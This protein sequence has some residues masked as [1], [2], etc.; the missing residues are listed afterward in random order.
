MTE[1]GLFSCFVVIFKHDDFGQSAYEA[2]GPDSCTADYSTLSEK[3]IPVENGLEVRGQR[4]GISD[5]SGIGQVE[6]FSG[7]LVI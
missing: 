5:C 4:F 1:F 3:N 2:A 6:W 7:F